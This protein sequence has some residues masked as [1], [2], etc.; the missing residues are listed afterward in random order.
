MS[1]VEAGIAANYTRVVGA[2][3]QMFHEIDLRTT[4]SMWR[5]PKP[6]LAGVGSCA[7]VN[8]K[9]HAEQKL[10]GSAL[11]M[12]IDM[13]E[14]RNAETP[15]KPDPKTGCPYHREGSGCVLHEL[16]SPACIGY[17][18]TF[19]EQKQRFGMTGTGLTGDI[20]WM[21]DEILDNTRPDID[22]FVE[23]AVDAIA[24]TTEHVRKYP[25]LHPGNENIQ[26]PNVI[27]QRNVH[28]G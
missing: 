17:N 11:Q 26:Q 10:H 27:F 25:I 15:G 22:T 20:W 21:L 13:R 5:S 8:S 9:K 16:K 1:K 19:R 12:L 14:A 7:I 4:G 6:V 3:D 28:I 23:D 24:K 2:L 18:E